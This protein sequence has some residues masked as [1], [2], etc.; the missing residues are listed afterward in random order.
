MKKLLLIL[1]LIP[2]I[3]VSQVSSWRNSSPQQQRVSPPIQQSVPQRNDVSRWRTQTAPIRPGDDFRN[4]PLTRRY[5]YTPMNPYG[6]MW[7]TWGW[8]QPYPYIWYDDFGYRNR[9]TVQIYEDGRLD[10]IRI[11]PIRFSAGISVSNDKQLGGWLTIGNRGYFIIDFSST[12][13]RDNS[14]FFPNGQIQNVDFPIVN[15]LVN[16]NTTYFGVGKKVNRTG[17]HVMFGV[18]NEDVKWRGRDEVGY[19]TFPKYKDKYVSAKV[20]LIHDFKVATIKLDFDPFTKVS[21]YGVG[22]NF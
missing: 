14:T 1:L 12:I 17:F 16:I 19:I 7:G 6:L 10:T 15:D 4:Q 13:S 9:A 11:K 21:T 5:R 8:Y 3:S 22:V 18:V 20:G 2:I